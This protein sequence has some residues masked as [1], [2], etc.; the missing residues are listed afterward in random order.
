ML[1]AI[2]ENDYVQQYRRVNGA[3]LDRMI[4]ENF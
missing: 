1:S 3:T 4:R 2:K